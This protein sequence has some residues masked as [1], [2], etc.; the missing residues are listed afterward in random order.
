M[1][2]IMTMT[3][4]YLDSIGMHYKILENKDIIQLG[5]GGLDNKGSMD[6]YVIFD[7]NDRTVGLRT[8]DLCQFP[9]NRKNVMYGVCNLLNCSY[10]WVKFYVDEND[11]TITAAD[12]AV[13][14]A[15]SSGQE[16]VE[17]IAHMAGVVDKAYPALMKAVWS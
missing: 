2:V 15:D 13:V 12:D 9:D 14:Q 3:T 16:I 8:H 17:L 11:N 4:A 6:L 7:D 10:R 1:G 5:I